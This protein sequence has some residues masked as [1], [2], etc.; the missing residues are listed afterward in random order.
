MYSLNH[1]IYQNWSSVSNCLIL[2]GI[3]IHLNCNQLLGNQLGEKVNLCQ[4]FIHR[5]LPMSCLT[6][7]NNF[8]WFRKQF[9]IW[10]MSCCCKWRDKT[11]ISW[12]SKIYQPS[13]EI[14]DGRFFQILAFKTRKSSSRLAFWNPKA[15]LGSARQ[16]KNSARLGSPKSRLGYN[17][18]SYLKM[19]KI[20]F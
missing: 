19:A 7:M 16:S 11:K 10:K 15:R 13:L 8:A 12:I 4:F 6:L 18:S 14:W 3:L 17:S 9:K 5:D 2:K 1:S 20:A